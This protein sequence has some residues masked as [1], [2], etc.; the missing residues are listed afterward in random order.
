MIIF[1]FLQSKIFIA[2]VLMNLLIA[3]CCFHF[4]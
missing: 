2:C 1:F 3:L 4:C